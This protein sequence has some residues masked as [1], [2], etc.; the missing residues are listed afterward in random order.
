MS[1]KGISIFDLLLLLK[2]HRA[3]KSINSKP[4]GSG[5]GVSKLSIS[6]NLVK[7]QH[8]SIPLFLAQKQHLN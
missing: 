5:E 6:I 8:L 1:I 4:A 2:Y 7:S 3:P